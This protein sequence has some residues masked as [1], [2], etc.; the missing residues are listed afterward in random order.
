ME[1]AFKSIGKK[2]FFSSGRVFMLHLQPVLFKTIQMTKLIGRCHQGSHIYENILSF[3]IC[4]VAK[5]LPA[6]CLQEEIFK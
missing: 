5:C 6:V 2:I 1:V 4:Y 3:Y